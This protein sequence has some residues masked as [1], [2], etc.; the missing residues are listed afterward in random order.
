MDFSGFGALAPCLMPKR[1]CIIR[2]VSGV[3]YR[4]EVIARHQ[5]LL[6]QE[7]DPPGAEFYQ[8]RRYVLNYDVSH[9]EEEPRNNRYM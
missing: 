7:Y 4:P 9:R 8:N 5:S 1:S 6:A 3:E 2:I